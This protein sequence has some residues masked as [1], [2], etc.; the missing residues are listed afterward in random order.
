V[1]CI[2]FNNLGICTKVGA[3]HS[4]EEV[5][6]MPVEFADIIIERGKENLVIKILWRRCT[7]VGDISIQKLNEIIF[8]CANDVG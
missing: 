4:R 5:K 7:F 3:W 2:W 6:N 1:L 8:L